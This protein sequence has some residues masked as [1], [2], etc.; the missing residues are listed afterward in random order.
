[1]KYI[2]CADNN[3]MIENDKLCKLRPIIKKFKTNIGSNSGLNKIFL[4]M[5]V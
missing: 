5:N 2:H 3:R 4:T 1:M